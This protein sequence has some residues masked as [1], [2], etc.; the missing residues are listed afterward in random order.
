MNMNN[1]DILVWDAHFGPNEGGTQLENLLNDSHLQR[2][3]I[4]LPDENFKV[5]GGYDYGIYIF[6][7]VEQKEVQEKKQLIER[8][9]N[10]EG[11]DARSLEIAD[12][13]KM[14]K[15][16]AG[17]EFS[18]AIQVPLAEIEAPDDMEIEVRLSFTLKE[19]I[20]KDA[21]L[22]IL[23]IDIDHK[24]VSYNKKDLLDVL[25]DQATKELVFP[26]KLKTNFP[27]GA[28][29]NLYVWNKDKKQLLINNLKLTINGL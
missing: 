28:I 8:A 1:G 6:K 23:S 22:L 3:K 11:I 7:R 27:Q 26:L 18:P 2:I 9:L 29:L 15:M 20:P 4:L 21:V 24:S 10:F 17:M 13:V 5:L 12:G 16:D 14:L 25:G 19:P